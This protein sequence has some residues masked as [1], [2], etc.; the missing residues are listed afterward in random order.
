VNLSTAELM[1]LEVLRGNLDAAIPL[2]DH[3]VNDV[4][5]KEARQIKPV[6]NMIGNG[7]RKCIAYLEAD[8]YG[9]SEGLQRIVARL[10]DW[11]DGDGGECLVLSGISRVELYEFPDE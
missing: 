6:H 1:A 5:Q 8:T 7:K 2:A 9:D 11:L 10:Q 3:L 4:Y